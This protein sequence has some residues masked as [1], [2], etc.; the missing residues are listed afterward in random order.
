MTVSSGTD[1][2]TRPSATFT[3]AQSA[4]GVMPLGSQMLPMASWWASARFQQLW[5]CL[6]AH[7]N[8]L[9]NGHQ[10]FKAE[11]TWRLKMQAIVRINLLRTGCTAQAFSAPAPFTKDFKYAGTPESVIDDTES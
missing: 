8:H 11:D 6:S 1:V 7:D 9:V 4:F 10:S 2:H 3:P 5:V